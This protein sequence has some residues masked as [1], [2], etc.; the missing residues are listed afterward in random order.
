M[1]YSEL[2]RML[3]AAGCRLEKHKTR[4]DWWFSPKTGQHFTVPRHQSEEV[5]PKTL[6]S[7]KK[8]AGLD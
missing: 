2:T 3:K 1:K 8:A 4:H 7:I 6:A 5:T